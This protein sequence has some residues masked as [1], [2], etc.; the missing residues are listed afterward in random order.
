MKQQSIPAQV[1]LKDPAPTEQPRD[2]GKED[3]QQ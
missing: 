3:A 1:P 2:I